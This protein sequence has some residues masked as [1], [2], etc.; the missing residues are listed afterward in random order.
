MMGRKQRGYPVKKKLA[1][2]EIIQKI[3]L[4]PSRSWAARTAR[5]TGGS[6]GRSFAHST[7]TSW[8]RQRKGRD[9]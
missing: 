3:G 1:A 8:T 5:C 4:L 7:E 6:V 2:V 9:I